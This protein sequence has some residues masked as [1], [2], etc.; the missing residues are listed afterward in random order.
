MRPAFYFFLGFV[1]LFSCRNSSL[2]GKWYIRNAE[3]YSTTENKEKKE[4][5]SC[6]YME[7][8][9]SG[10]LISGT[11]N[12]KLESGWHQ[13]GDTVIITYN[14]ERHPDYL[15]ID[16]LTTDTLILSS[17][18]QGEMNFK[19]MLSPKCDLP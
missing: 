16:L 6:D 3:L 15:K 10:K 11:N 1:F 13:S 5:K 18:G 4:Y 17:I 8:K 7:F 12:L 9:T 2:S 19:L 14:D